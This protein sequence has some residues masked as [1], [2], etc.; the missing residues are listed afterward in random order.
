METNNYRG[1]MNN[2]WTKKAKEAANI[3]ELVDTIHDEKVLTYSASIVVNAKILSFAG[4]TNYKSKEIILDKATRDVIVDVLSTR[5]EEL[6]RELKE[7][8]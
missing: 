8:L 6:R 3:A 1:E 2:D 4:E 7:E 5:L